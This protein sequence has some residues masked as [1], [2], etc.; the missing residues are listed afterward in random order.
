MIAQPDRNAAA[1]D[2]LTPLV[3]QLASQLRATRSG[4]VLAKTFPQRDSASRPQLRTTLDTITHVSDQ[5][6]AHRE[7]IAAQERKLDE[8]ERR[9]ETLAG[10]FADVEAK[11]RAALDDSRHQR[12]R[13]DDLERRSADLLAKT[14]QML[15]EAGE[16]LQ[17]AEVRAASATDDLGYLNDFIQERLGAR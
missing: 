8:H 10:Q 14:Q 12:A 16:R 11:L 3:R 2:A 6:R 7:L 4:A 1:D 15:T 9:I 17:A 13:A 5:R